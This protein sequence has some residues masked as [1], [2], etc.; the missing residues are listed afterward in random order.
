MHHHLHRLNQG[1]LR[2]KPQMHRHLLHRLLG[3]LMTP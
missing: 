2:E 3:L 1:L